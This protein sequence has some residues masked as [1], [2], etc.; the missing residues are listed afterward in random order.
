MWRCMHLVSV[1][2]PHVPLQ[3]FLSDPTY[4]HPHPTTPLPH[5]P[6]TPLPHHPPPQVPLKFVVPPHPSDPRWPA[7]L[8]GIELGV[9]CMRIRG[10]LV[11]RKYK[12]Q[13]VEM[14][15]SFADKRY[16][17]GFKMIKAAVLRYQELHHTAQVSGV[18]GWD[19]W[20]GRLGRVVGKGGWYWYG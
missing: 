20:E 9:I 6:T 2:L 16:R 3:L 1:S 8:A 17:Y 13:L 15:F 14:G 4:P 11:M 18:V 7:T 5:Y 12:Q 19:G 10:G